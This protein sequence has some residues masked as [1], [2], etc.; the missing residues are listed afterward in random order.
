MRSWLPATVIC[1]HKLT[2]RP[3]NTSQIPLWKFPSY[4]FLSLPSSCSSPCSSFSSWVSSTG[5]GAAIS[6]S[7]SSSWTSRFDLVFIQ[8]WFSKGTVKG[9]EN[10]HLC[11][12]VFYLLFD[13]CVSL[14]QWV[15]EFLCSMKPFPSG[16]TPPGSLWTCPA[17]QLHVYTHIPLG[18]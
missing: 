13:R 7:S 15:S 18:K 12:C 3:I 1:N 5:G 14:P 4:R 17:S 2:A 10:M 11:L 8:F 16:R 9:W 6:S